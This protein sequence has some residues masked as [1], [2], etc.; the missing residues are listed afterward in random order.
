[1]PRKR[2]GP[3]PLTPAERQRQH[4][5]KRKEETRA[6]WD[7]LS[8]MLEART[9]RERARIAEEVLKGKADD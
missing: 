4:R 2:I 1:M 7:A 5:A 6:L 3:D 8:R 9:K